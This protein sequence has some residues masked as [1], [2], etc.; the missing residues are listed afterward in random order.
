M[1]S[2]SGAAP[3]SLAGRIVQSLGRRFGGRIDA[4]AALDLNHIA[5]DPLPLVTALGLLAEGCGH[6]T[7]PAQLSAALPVGEHGLDPRFAPIAMA[8]AGLEARWD[9]ARIA[10]VAPDDFPLLAP[11]VHGGAVLALARA[12]DGLVT[13]RDARGEKRVAA[14]DLQLLLGDELLLCGHVDPENGA[15][16]TAERDLV[17]RNPRLWLLGIFMGEKRKLRQVLIAAALLNLCALAIPLY[18]RAIYDRVVPN[19]AIESLWALS[20][21]VMLVLMFEFMLKHIRGAFVDAVGVR[22]GQA[23][24]HRA[25][26]AFLHARD[27]RKDGNVGTLMTA[28]RD[29]EGLALLGPQALVT[30]LV[31]VPF[32]FAYLALIGLIG[33]WTMVGPLLGA[34][35]LVVAGIVTSYALKLSSKRATKLMQARNNL[36]V[37]VAEG[38]GTIKASQAEG[39]FLRQW[40]LVSDHIGVSTRD[41]R[42]WNDLP[43]SIAGF[44]VQL[45]TVLVVIIGVF[46]IKSGAMTTGALVAVTM[47]TGRAMVPV[48]GAV[49]VIAKVYQSLSQFSGLAGILALDPEREA[50]D[51]AIARRPVEGRFAM[52]AVHYRYPEAAEPSLTDISLSIAPGEK[53]ALIGRS[54]S[55]KSTLLQMLAGMIHPDEG[56]MTVDGH[57]VNQ[58]AAAHLR[59]SIVYSGQDAALFNASIWENILLGMDEP[60][61]AIVDRA[62]RISCLDRFVSRSVEGYSRKVGPAGSRL[63][64]GQRQSVLLARALIRDP[65]I[66][67]LDEPT[68]AMDINAEQAVIAGLRAAMAERTVVLATHRMALLDLVDRIIWLEEGRIVAD[69]PRAEMLAILRRQQQSGAARA[70]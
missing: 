10:H 62:I 50:S 61:E 59:R 64:G 30:F 39:R 57:A 17:R 14:G 6:P 58:Y 31:D 26:A 22:I 69:R 9:R 32:F 43:G 52:K 70:A 49:S 42:K 41:A 8:R 23:V 1:P 28:L 19:L 68:S 25:M 51:P 63:S 44:M 4:A 66:L 20:T 37:D 3:I 5:I 38:I 11:L 7:D 16:Y 27:A 67:L 18:M 36:V 33:G 65:A 53:I 35:A 47:L 45:V 12:A 60:N 56:M 34:M 55:G 40:D 24:Q 29:V 46:Q 48:S 15:G 2:T 54:G 21:G 13:I